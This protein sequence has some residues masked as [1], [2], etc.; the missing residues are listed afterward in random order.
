MTDE[1]LK[2]CREYSLSDSREKITTI[3]VRTY[4]DQQYINLTCRVRTLKLWAIL[5]CDARQNIEILDHGMPK[6][7][8]GKQAKK[9]P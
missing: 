6:K 7:R 8:K 2:L 9:R 4:V 5:T 3:Y 1:K